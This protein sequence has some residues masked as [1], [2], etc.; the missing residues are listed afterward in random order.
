[1]ITVLLF[2]LSL[3]FCYTRWF[4]WHSGLNWKKRVVCI[5]TVSLYDRDDHGPMSN[6]YEVKQ[7]CI[8]CCVVCTWWIFYAWE[9]RQKIRLCVKDKLVNFL[10]VFF[11]R[12]RWK[13]LRYKTRNLF[14]NIS[15]DD[16]TIAMICI[17]FDDDIWYYTCDT[18]VQLSSKC[19]SFVEIHVFCTYAV[20]VVIGQIL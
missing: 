14:Y 1:M 11:L 10:V 3:L 13:R 17:W 2:C 18:L 5:S 15:F 7:S 16:Y 8:P 12:E 19:N 20:C 9:D 4:Y 6:D